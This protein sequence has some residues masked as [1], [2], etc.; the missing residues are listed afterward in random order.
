MRPFFS[1]L[2]CACQ[3][4]ED[5][6]DSDEE[7]N[8]LSEIDANM[9]SLL[10]E[11]AKEQGTQMGASKTAHH[12]K[13]AHDVNSMLRLLADAHGVLK[14]ARPAGPHLSDEERALVAAVGRGDA[15]EVQRLLVVPGR[16][17]MALPEGDS[18]LHLA[19][20]CGS[21]ARAKSTIADATVRVEQGARGSSL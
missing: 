13:L 17:N 20:R 7:A 19:C 5:E 10:S 9:G 15:A 14:G 21:S 8:D 1:R 12:P 2:W 16:S 6:S 3:D 11:L 18:L 4:S